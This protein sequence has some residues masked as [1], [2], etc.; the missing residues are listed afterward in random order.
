MPRRNRRRALSCRTGSRLAA[1][2]LR[3]T[4]RQS[5]LANRSRRLTQMDTSVTVAGAI[6]RERGDHATKPGCTRVSDQRTRRTERDRNPRL[7]GLVR[8]VTGRG[9]RGRCQLSCP[10]R[11]HPG[12]GSGSS[13]R[14]RLLEPNAEYNI[15]HAAHAFPNSERAE[16]MKLGFAPRRMSR[17]R[18]RASASHLAP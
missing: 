10:R 16:R 13:P 15:P 8:H 17:R 14:R 2:A 12:S 1:R 3:R 7:Y 5:L 18:G 9:S 4:R 11:R 6:D